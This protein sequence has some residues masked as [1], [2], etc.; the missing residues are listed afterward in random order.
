MKKAARVIGSLAMACALAAGAGVARAEAPAQDVA[1]E[2]VVDGLMERGIELRRS[3]RDE[4][5][6]AVFAT[7]LEQAPDSTRIKVHLAATYQ[8][9]GQWVEAERFLRAASADPD[10]AY[11]RRHRATIEK[12]YAF[13]EQ[14]LGSLEVVGGPDGAELVL[15]GRTVASLPLAEPVRVPVG[16]YLLEVRKPGYYTISRP[17]TIGAGAMLRESV[18]LGERE[19]RT[20]GPDPVAERAPAEAEADGGGSPRWLTWTLGGAG[21]GALAI[22]AVAFGV[23][24]KHAARWNS[25]DCTAPDSTRGEVCPGELDSGRSAERWGIGAAVASGVFFGGA[26]TSYFL[27]RREPVTETVRLD[28]C[29]LGLGAA[30]CF[31]SF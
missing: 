23:R 4:D 9:L 7:A 25:D 3:G 30:R 18:V 1:P 16:S 5:A 26:L 24:E 20:L 29:S 12:A 27:E 17:V 21:I 8:A 19:Q 22:S 6:L 11:I 13:I 28:G 2:A 14:R 10:D 15:S 31:G